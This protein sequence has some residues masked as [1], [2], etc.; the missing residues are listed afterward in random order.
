M[1]KRNSWILTTHSSQHAPNILVAFALT[2]VSVVS[3]RNSC[4]A[5]WASFDFICEDKL[6]SLIKRAKGD[7]WWTHTVRTC[8][9][10]QLE[11]LVR[12]DCRTSRKKKNSTHSNTPLFALK[13]KYEDI[14]LKIKLVRLPSINQLLHPIDNAEKKSYKP[15]V[16]C[17]LSSFAVWTLPLIACYLSL[18]NVV[19]HHTNIQTVALWDYSSFSHIIS[20]RP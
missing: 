11:I 9:D 15:V 17:N 8:G 7:T 12:K 19:L 4:W 20:V 14:S 10:K 1:V 6:S 3:V 5:Q 16:C 13:E 2:F 18:Q